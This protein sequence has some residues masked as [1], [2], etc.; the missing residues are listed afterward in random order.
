MCSDPETLKLIITGVVLSI[1]TIGGF[2][3]LAIIAW[4]MS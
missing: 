2:G 4:R 3:C 1:V